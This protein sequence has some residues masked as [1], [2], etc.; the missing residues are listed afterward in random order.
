[1]SPYRTPAPE[2]EKASSRAADEDRSASLREERLIYG[3]CF[4]FGVSR[5]VHA[6]LFEHELG[7]TSAIAILL[8]GWG[9]RAL[10]LQAVQRLRAPK[11]HRHGGSV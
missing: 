8:G 4:A 6:V 2:P 7:V 3:F 11:E 9:A 5:I 1:M 10:A